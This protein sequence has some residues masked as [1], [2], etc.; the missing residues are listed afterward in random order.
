MGRG[1]HQAL[2]GNWAL[3]GEAWGSEGFAVSPS[4]IPLS[5]S[6]L[7]LA[8]SLPLTSPSLLAGARVS[9]RRGETDQERSKRSEHRTVSPACGRDARSTRLLA[10]RVEA[11]R[12]PGSETHRPL[13]VNRHVVGLPAGERR[14]KKGVSEA[15]TEPSR[16]LAGETRGA[17]ASWRAASKQRGC[18]DPRPIDL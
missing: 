14:T 16:P 4:H 10:G 15:N 11:E 5:A 6:I 12:V 17:P 9:P 2:E 3:G 8:A 18:R 1:R 7:R 13:A